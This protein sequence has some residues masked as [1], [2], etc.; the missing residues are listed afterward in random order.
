MK[1]KE[2]TGG[3]LFAAAA[4]VVM[5]FSV[6]FPSLT[7]TCAALAGFLVLFV[8]LKWGMRPAVLCYITA[9][10]LALVLVPQKET[11]LEFLLFFGIYPMLKLRMERHPS[12]VACWACKLLFCNVMLAVGY[13]LCLLLGIPMAEM[14]GQL[15][16]MLLALNAVFVLYDCCF[17]RVMRTVMRR[18]RKLF[19]ND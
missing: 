5:L 1:T 11:A 7:L 14:G 16:V 17:T 3:G 15:P 19:L 13:G 6:P 8:M 2:I 18:Y 9:G 4:V 10:V 12:P